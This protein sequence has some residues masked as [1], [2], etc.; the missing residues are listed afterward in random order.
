M[1][2]VVFIISSIIFVSI[3]AIGSVISAPI[4]KL[5]NKYTKLERISE[6]L[7]KKDPAT[8]PDER[9]NDLLASKLIDH[10]NR[11]SELRPQEFPSLN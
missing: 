8:E 4:V 11:M 1:V 6:L 7:Q 9:I 3:V 2:F 10:D 5:R